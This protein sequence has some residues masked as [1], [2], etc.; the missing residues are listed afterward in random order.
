[1]ADLI[2]A[3]DLGTTGNKASLF[4]SSGRLVASASAYYETSYPRPGWAEQNPATWWQA[5]IDST[6][7]LLVESGRSP[8][9]I[10]VIGFSG[11]MMGCLPVDLHGM[12]LFPSIIWADQRASE[13]AEYIAARVGFD[14]VYRITGH[15]PGANYTAAKLLWLKRHEPEIYANTCRI[16]QAKDYIAW[17][18]TDVFATDYSDASGT[19][20]Y[21]LH[22]RTWSD[23][24]LDAIGIDGVLLP[25]PLPSATVIGEITFKAAVATGLRA[26]TPV[27]IGGG[28]GGCATVG[29]G[30]VQPGDA[31]NYIGSSSWLAFT[32][33]EPL[34]DRVQR[35]FTFAHLDPQYYFPTGTM[36][37][38]GGAYDW[39][40]HLL[41]G[42]QEY[43]YYHDLD[44]LAESVEP[45]ARGLLFMPYLIGERSPHWSTSARAAFVGLTMTHGRA[46]MARAVLEGVAFNLRLILDAF[47]EQGAEF[48]KLRILGGGARSAVWRQILADIFEVPLLRLA[49]P[50]E[51]T[52]MGAAIAAGVGVGIYRG[53]D[54]AAELIPTEPGEEPNPATFACYHAMYDLFKRSYAALAP[55]Y[56]T[57][58]Q[59][60]RNQT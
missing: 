37:T 35:T 50:S 23:K 11:H 2:L 21:D 56:T 19:N 43:R 48:G 8:Q 49:L 4:D 39:Y 20:L 12:P 44:R 54:I 55:I 10:A 33:P 36:Q 40:E 32:A 24:I 15:R 57:L 6:R 51:A 9:E 31:Y 58:A 27:V 29:A 16:L 28:D 14:E 22:R 38:A 30:V 52:A 45:G 59:T 34:Y 18:L 53:Y 17:K 26:G 3:H 5:V 60:A 13:E 46:E 25:Q 47:R 42:A 7:R 41:H 1:M